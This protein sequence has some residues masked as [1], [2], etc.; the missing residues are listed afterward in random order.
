M[1]RLFQEKAV[2]AIYINRRA[3]ESVNCF[4]GIADVIFLP[5]SLGR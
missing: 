4:E 5:L 2:G 1:E 3:S